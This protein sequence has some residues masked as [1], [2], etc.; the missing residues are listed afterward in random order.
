M[1]CPI[2]RDECFEI[3]C[4]WWCEDFGDCAIALMGRSLGELSF[5]A[6]SANIDC[7]IR[8][9]VTKEEVVPCEI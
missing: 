1:Y 7:G 5:S 9:H 4:E 8:V 2:T 6:D 3:G